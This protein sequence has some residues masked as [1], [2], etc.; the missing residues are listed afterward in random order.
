[1]SSSHETEQGHHPSF[2]QYALVAAIL[3]A[4][5]IVE[6]FAIWPDPDR[7]GAAKIPVLVILSA[8]KFAIVIMFYMH[9]KFDN[10]MFTIFFL[11]GLFLAFGVGIALLGLFTALG[12]GPARFS[13]YWECSSLL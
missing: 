9:L 4:I 12:G 11:A 8:I 10:R 13:G 2:M 7:I 1:M 3:F 6:F 5:T